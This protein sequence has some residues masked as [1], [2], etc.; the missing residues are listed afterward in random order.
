M[1]RI[2][3]SL[4]PL[5]RDKNKNETKKRKREKNWLVCSLQNAN[6]ENVAYCQGYD[7]NSNKKGTG[8]HKMSLNLISSRQETCG[9]LNEAVS[10]I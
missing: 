4:L 6:F 8:N 7:A 1:Y 5:E 3:L 10:C 9:M 2:H